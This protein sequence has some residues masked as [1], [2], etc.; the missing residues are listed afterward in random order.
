M[1]IVLDPLF[2]HLKQSSSCKMLPS[3]SG[4]CPGAVG[5]VWSGP[6]PASPACL[7]SGRDW[8]LIHWSLTVPEGNPAG[9]GKCKHEYLQ[10]LNRL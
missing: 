6:G 3:V 2:C 9:E 4:G 7:D 5:C 1:L 8:S 10:W